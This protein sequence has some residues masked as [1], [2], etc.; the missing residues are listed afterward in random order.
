MAKTRGSGG[1]TI[2]D[3][4]ASIGLAHSTVSRALNDHPGIGEETK[5]LVRRAAADLNYVANSGARLMR[6]GT[7]RVVGLILPD[8]E[9]DFYNS[10][11]RI[12]AEFCDAE[13]FQL[14]LAVSEDDPEKECKQVLA[15]R[16]A[17]VAGL[18]IAATLNPRR[19]TAQMLRQLP[20]VQF[21][22]RHASIR[23]PSIRADDSRGLRIATDHLVALGH[24]RIAFIGVHPEL[25]TG[26]DRLDGYRQSLAAARIVEVPQY[27]RAG[28]P[29]PAFA[30]EALAD[31]LAL[32][33][34]P[35]G[36]VV[37]SP[38]LVL[39]ALDVISQQNIAVPDELSFV[40]Y[41]DVEWFRTW[42]PAITAVA[43]PTA[44]MATT[45]ASL[46]FRTIRKPDENDVE[47]GAPFEPTLLVRAS[48]GPAHAPG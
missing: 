20:A 15:F 9:N 33:D 21:L 38:R 43:L 34:P 42:R 10:A 5:V 32:S 4:A 3:V 19:E 14:L 31:L 25:S 47:F 11:T 6:S 37:A 29:Q 41:S 8:I 16:E 22:R 48:T 45:A 24:K 13:N 36:V 7:S 23:S 27:V 35:S 28:S 1:V 46:L 39:G 18:V 2:K 26:R 12:M 30:R 40:A 44:A 17:R